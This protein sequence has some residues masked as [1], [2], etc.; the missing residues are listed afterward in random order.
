M[1]TK[2][3]SDI[4][5]RREWALVFDFGDEAMAGLKR[6]AETERLTAAHFT[7]IGAFS[8][9]KV[10]WFDFEARTYRPIKI[11]EQVEVVS[12]IGDIAEADGKPSVHV[13]LCVARKDGTAHGGHLQEGRVRPTLEVILIE[14]PAH[15][16]K[17][18]RPE[19]GLALIDL[20]RSS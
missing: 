6:F 14:S 19:F 3:L 13:H 4:A 18:F 11:G 10:A 1:K 2:L 12:L 15:L 16:R 7:G 9:V 20:D 8:H 17:T 5:G